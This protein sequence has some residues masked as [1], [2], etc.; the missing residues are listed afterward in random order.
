MTARNHCDSVGIC[1]NDDGG[2]DD[3]G[4]CG[5]GR[6]NGEGEGDARFLNRKK[7]PCCSSSSLDDDALPLLLC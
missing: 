1:A 3:D 6:G 7:L 5:E 4:G 2:G